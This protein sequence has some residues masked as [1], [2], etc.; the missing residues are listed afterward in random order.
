MNAWCKHCR[1]E[2]S[3][4]AGRGKK[5]K[6]VPC[7]F[8]RGPLE[9]PSY[10]YCGGCGRKTHALAQETTLVIFRQH[11]ERYPIWVLKDHPICLSCE[12]RSKQVC[13]ESC[14]KCGRA[15]RAKALHEGGGTECTVLQCGYWFCY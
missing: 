1:R 2:V 15:M 9:R 7:T 8:C 3:W 12:D 13:K 4:Y 6:D 10:R 14:P 11:D 5:L